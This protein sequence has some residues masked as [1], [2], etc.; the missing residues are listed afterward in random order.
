MPLTVQGA[1]WQGLERRQ[2]RVGTQVGPAVQEEVVHLVMILLQESTA[3]AGRE[4]WWEL[5][6][7]WGR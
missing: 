7:S 1:V 3:Q 2:G 5:G 4:S 6:T